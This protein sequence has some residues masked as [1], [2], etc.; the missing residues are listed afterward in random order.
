MMKDVHEKNVSFYFDIEEYIDSKITG[1]PVDK[2][3]QK[4]YAKAW[5]N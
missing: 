4:K 3:M 2:L 5:L 1:T